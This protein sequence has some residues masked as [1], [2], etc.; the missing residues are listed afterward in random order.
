MIL[1]KKNFVILLSEAYFQRVV[2]KSFVNQ[3]D[4]A[5]LFLANLKI[6]DGIFE[7]FSNKDE[8]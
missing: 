2:R 3:N 4:R 8:Y 7:E 5:W 1:I 6:A